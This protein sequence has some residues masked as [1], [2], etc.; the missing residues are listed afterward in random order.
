MSAIIMEKLLGKAS[1][2][3]RKYGSGPVHLSIES[4]FMGHGT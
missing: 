1:E 4:I 2:A 3:L